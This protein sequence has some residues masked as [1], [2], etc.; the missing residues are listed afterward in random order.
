MTIFLYNR[1]IILQELGN[2]VKSDEIWMQIKLFRRKRQNLLVSFM[3]YFSVS[4]GVFFPFFSYRFR[5]NNMAY[6]KNTGLYSSKF[7]FTDGQTIF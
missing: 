4:N 3:C 6:D 7:C 2:R 1:D 5:V